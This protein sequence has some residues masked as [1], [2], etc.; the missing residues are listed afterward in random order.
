MSVSVQ[1]DVMKLWLHRGNVTVCDQISNKRKKQKHN[2][3]HMG[4]NTKTVLF[5]LLNILTPQVQSK[6]DL[7]LQW[8]KKIPNQNNLHR[9]PALGDI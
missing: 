5:I 1:T 3:E 7:I 8:K 4:T 9:Q 2:F 6:N